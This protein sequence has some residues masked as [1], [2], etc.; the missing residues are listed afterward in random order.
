MSENGDNKNE[1]HVA[2]SLG[3]L[4]SEWRLSIVK[5]KKRKTPYRQLDDG[6][7]TFSGLGWLARKCLKNGYELNGWRTNC[8]TNCK[9]WL[10]MFSFGE[11]E[12]NMKSITGVV[13]FRESTEIF[14]LSQSWQT[15]GWVS[16]NCV[17]VETDIGVLTSLLKCAYLTKEKY[18]VRCRIVLC[19]QFLKK[20]PLVLAFKWKSMLASNDIQLS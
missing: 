17:D 12:R 11:G 9:P 18:V 3:T 19:V 7:S 10:N 1:I 2:P 4:A 5:K 6:M 14:E 20:P 8:S 15:D 13:G 16:T